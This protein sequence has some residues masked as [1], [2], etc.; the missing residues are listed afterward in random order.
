MTTPTFAQW[1]AH[2]QAGPGLAVSIVKH[3][4]AMALAAYVSGQNPD[5]TVRGS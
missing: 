4:W 5:G 3:R 2:S 1:K